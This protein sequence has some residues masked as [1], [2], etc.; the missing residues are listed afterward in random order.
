MTVCI[1]HFHISYRP[2]QSEAPV[3]SSGV[4]VSGLREGRWDGGLSQCFG[5]WFPA[6]NNT[7]IQKI[8]IFEMFNCI[9]HLFGWLVLGLIQN[10]NALFSMEQISLSLWFLPT[11]PNMFCKAP[12]WTTV[13]IDSEMIY[14]F[15]PQ[16]LG[17]MWTPQRATRRIWNFWCF[18]WWSQG[19]IWALKTFGVL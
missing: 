11:L 3:L 13:C 2:L 19:I 15:I 7:C 10:P 1:N 4:P 18:V 17:P 8:D 9:V 6:K 12:N 16:Q 5:C 14:S